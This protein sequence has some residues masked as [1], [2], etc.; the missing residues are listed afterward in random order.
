MATL[1][2]GTVG[3]V[4]GGP[5]GGIVGTLLGSTIDR[6]IFGTTTR[7]GPRLA[8]LAVQSAA[9]GQPLLRVYGRMRVAG[10]LIWT[11]GIKETMQRSGGKTGTA[12]NNYTYSSSF[13]VIVAARPI[14]HIER[15]WADGKLLRA[16]DGT[17]N[18]PATIRTYTGDEAQ[19]VD[20]LI[21]AAEGADLAPAYRGRA[22]I[23]FEDLPLADY[24][25]RIPNL[26]FEVV[27][28]PGPVGVGTIAV[29]LGAGVIAADGVW[30][31][32]IGFAA[33][34]AGT[35]RQSLTTL[36]AIADLTLH[37]D[38]AALRLGLEAPPTPIPAAAAG[39]TDQTSFV[40]ER[41]ENRAADTTVPD[42]IWLSYSDPDRDYQAG[43]QA[44]TRRT[45]AVRIEQHDLT[46]TASA[47]DAKALA[48]SA[49]R[50]AIAGRTTA[51]LALPWRYATI[52]SGDTVIAGDDPLPWRVTHRT[53]T[54]A[55]ID[56]D[57]DRV[58]GPAAAAPMLAD[59]GRSYAAT[60]APQGATILQILDVPALP[61]PLPT[62]PQLLLAA[63]GVSA[64]WRR[65]DIL[66]SRDG[67]ESYAFATTIGAP[68]TIGTTV[69]VLPAGTTSRWDRRSTLDVELAATD[70]DLQSAGEAAVL[71]GANLAVVGNELI[72]FATAT[73]LGPQR[74]RL[75]T[76]LRGRRGSENAIGGH[77]A[78]ERFVL[79]DDRV[80]TLDLPAEALGAP[81]LFKAVGPADDAATILPQAVTPG[82]VAL[83]PLSPATVMI[84]RADNG[85]RII[86]WQRRSRAGFAWSDGTDAPLAEDSER[87]RITI[88]N[89]STIVRTADVTTPSW[90]YV[91]AAVASDAAAAA[92]RSLTI[93]V[94]Q[95]SA[96]VGPGVATTAALT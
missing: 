49:L 79:L 30:P 93:A 95:V 71:A 74:Y 47:S 57:L 64:G 27:A 92:T 55:V 76:L 37:D 29:D 2:L 43:V 75:S 77:S 83:R 39:A 66:L 73:P 82:G 11:A 90:T 61:G 58:A 60:D 91:A 34:Q 50:R 5:I 21:A 9:Y 23:V 87:Y 15:I 88:S 24:G 1:I 96:V 19:A 54:G 13:A 20:P 84:G 42:A 62:S 51:K 17:F 78:G 44:A 48:A 70:A 67:G 53:I 69:G 40:P 18:F 56:F 59:A 16:A 63:T 41:H 22:M 35:M 31:A 65:A 6:G 10:N 89:G 33:A 45:P 12:T 68:A 94:A 3:R 80:A 4:L 85:D 81:L 25:N 86:T 72:Q 52:R 26:T 46:I 8:D 36:A 28:D 32:V 7:D 14:D 38:G